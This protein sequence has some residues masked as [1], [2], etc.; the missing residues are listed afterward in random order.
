MGSGISAMKNIG[1]LETRDDDDSLAFRAAEYLRDSIIEAV[2]TRGRAVVGLSGGETP[3]PA[4]KRL[5][6]LDIPWKGVHLVW[7]DDRFVP[8]SSPRSNYGTALGDWI[9]RIAI[10]E[11]QVH[12]MPEAGPDH[13]GRARAYEAELRRVCLVE[14]SAPPESIV[15]DVALMGVGDDGHTASLFP[16]SFALDVRDRAVV[17]VPGEPSREPRTSLTFPV[18]ESVR[19]MLVLCQG[20]KKRPQIS[21]ARGE[22]DIPAARLQRA[23][24]EITWLVDRAAAP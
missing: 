1:T 15:L 4:Y 19:K 21:A 16:G 13:E 22:G 10:P 14:E 9:S 6:T 2:K 8:W 12:P 3:R 18:L 7:I 24:G 17:A 5:A 20:A 11:S 23:R